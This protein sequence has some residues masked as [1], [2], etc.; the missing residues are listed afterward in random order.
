M[1]HPLRYA[2]QDLLWFATGLFTAA[3]GLAPDRA[4][5]VAEVLV[6]GDLYGQTT[7]GL[8]LAA[9]YLDALA[10]GDMAR[11][12]EPA[13]L[14]RTALAETWDGK[15]LPGPWLVRRAA[16]AAS[17]AARE[18]GLGA[19][20]IGRS[21][22]I[23]CLSAYLEPVTARGQMIVMAS[24]DPATASVA[25]AGGT[26]RLIT[27][28]PLAAGWPTPAGAALLDISMSYTTNAMTARRRA[29][30]RDFGH[31]W[32]LDAE[33]RPT[34]DPNAFFTDP[35]GTLAPLGAPSAGHK[36]FAL[37]LLVET[38]TSAL[39]GH[40]RAE[41]PTGWGA[42]VF[43]LVLD[44]ARF[45]G[46]GAFLRETGWMEAAIEANPPAAG[47]APHLP[48]AGARA[49]KAEACARGVALHPSIMP[50]LAAR[51]DAAGIEV[52]KPL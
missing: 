6:E 28:N 42:N 45:G 19:V 37:G 34:R 29:E 10:S 30:G 18:H 38:L 32:L 52:P 3:G 21:H 23:G 47:G 41:T 22:H 48:G 44:P 16:E 35:P 24:S 27:P 5:A 33:G 15:K 17:S 50:A 51:A 31:P 9:P 43:V 20:V 1:T 7:H 36:G 14:N 13:L 12:G 39:A 4:Q 49:R 8:A 46:A 11:E 26:R 25:P 2:A 40:G